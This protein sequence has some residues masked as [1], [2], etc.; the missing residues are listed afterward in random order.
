[1][2]EGSK[3]EL[4]FALVAAAGTNLAKAHDCLRRALE[5]RRFTV[6]EVRLSDL[7][8][9]F[10]LDNRPK[11][12]HE[13]MRIS[14]A[15]DRG[16][17]IREK[18]GCGDAVARLGMQRIAAKRAT[19]TSMPNR[20]RSGIAYVIRSLKHPQEVNCL[21]NVYKDSF[22]VISLYEPKALRIK[23]IVEEIRKTRKPKLARPIVDEYKA[24]KNDA[25]KIV[26]RD[27]D[28]TDRKL[29]QH[30]QDTIYLA[31]FFAAVGVESRPLSE[32]IERYI[33][34]LFGARFI[35][36]TLDEVAS[37][38]AQAAAY[39]S[40]DLSRQVGAVITSAD[41]TLIA[42]GYNE[43]P[44]TGG[45]HFVEGRDPPACDHRD[46]TVDM[47]ASTAAKH[48]LITE[49]FLSLISAKWLKDKYAKLKEVELTNLA[50]DAP[51]AEIDDGRGNLIGTRVT[52][53]L[54]FGRIV[55]A[56]MSAL[57]E[58]A[59]RGR[60]VEDATLYCTTFPCHICAKHVIAAGIR[61][62]V[63]IE[64]YP[65]SQA[66]AL[67]PDSIH[68][69]GSDCS[70][71]NPVR[72][73][74]FVG[75]APRQY[76]RMFEMRPRKDKTTGYAIRPDFRDALPRFYAVSSA[77]YEAEA[78]FISTLSPLSRERQVRS[79][80]R[81]NKIVGYEIITKAVEEVMAWPEWKKEQFRNLD[82]ANSYSSVKA[83]AEPSK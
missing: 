8:E 2:A 56:E 19:L 69:D 74:P 55:H 17:R 7:I 58:A 78:W 79:R 64:P 18:L 63:Y 45:G 43:V 41:G 4:V 51:K 42:S 54:E 36:P 77:Y 59:R 52:N 81:A 6:M 46:Y 12:T 27:E 26:A 57:T 82:S 24:W 65:K 72:F 23:R 14:Q 66:T 39:R 30:L 37:F 40:A 29:G 22:H 48:E 5:S 10:A 61:R 70:D 21:R 11:A 73:E 28:E 20:R 80:Q 75:V 31:D 33:A 1:M 34:L 60:A 3:P 9:Q 53:L 15:M 67:Y 35:T 68:V 71:P 38:F 44:A 50:L 62:V 76:M 25:E 49:V 16:T 13:D 32:Q 83:Q 47:D